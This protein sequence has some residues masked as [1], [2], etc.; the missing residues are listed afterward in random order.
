[1]QIL[2]K[3]TVAILVLLFVSDIAHAQE[4]SQARKDR[5]LLNLEYRFPQLKNAKL[6]I[7]DIAPSKYN[8]LDIGS[9]TV[10]SRNGTQQQNFLISRDDTE[11]YMYSGAPLNVSLT[12]AQIQAEIEQKEQ[13]E[14]QIANARL[15]ELKASAKTRPSKGNPTGSVLIVEFSDFQCPY[16]RRAI[17]TIDQMMAKYG[18]DVRFVYKHFPLGFHPWAKPA[19]IASECVA[20]QNQKV[21]WALHDYYYEKQKSINPINLIKKT[22]EFLA[23]K[24]LDMNAWSTCAEDYSSR[25]YK[26]AAATVDA[27]IALGQKLGVTGTPGF[28]VDGVFING[29]QPLSTF[30]PIIDNALG[31]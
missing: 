17:S 1:M 14:A 2:F 30:E 18:N 6:T 16:C 26:N 3:Y 13:A 31:K 20:N 27:D 24:G 25:Q 15:A 9:F 5:I 28:F 12:P 21:F 10:E 7:G 23:N 8:G 19:A 29:A 22:K 4:N 11:L